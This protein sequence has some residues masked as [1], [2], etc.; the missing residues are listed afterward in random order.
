[1]KDLYIVGA[2][3]FGRE[4]LN[5][6][7]DIHAIAG[8]RWNIM[9]FLDDT[10]DPLQNKTC[11]F[12][13]VGSIVD[14][15]PKP[16]DVLALAIGNPADKRKLASMLT[17]RGAKFETIIYPYAN[18]GRHNTLGEGCIVC[19]GTGMTVNITIGN[20]VTL[21]SCGL[22]HDVRI[23]DYST[24]SPICNIMGNVTLGEGVFLGGNS[25]IAPHTHIG[26]NAYVCIGSIVIKDVPVGAKVMGNPAREIG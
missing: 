24:I 17:A 26:N 23:G 25:V 11:D 20:F 9:G 18:L 7:L 15:S 16:N 6:V 13:V 3:G 4:V 10:E 12:S 22:G 8:P 1:M 2:G 21:L 5:L 19:G 14:Y